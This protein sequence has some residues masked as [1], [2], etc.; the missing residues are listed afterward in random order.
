V[1]GDIGGGPLAGARISLE[2]RLLG[3]TDERGRLRLAAAGL[4][5]RG[6][7]QA[8]AD[9][10]APG[11]ASFVVP[12]AAALRLHPQSAVAGVV[13]RS[14]DGRPVA[15]VTVTAGGLRSISDGAGR[16]ALRGLGPGIYTLEAQSERWFGRSAHPLALGMGRTEHDVRLPVSPAFVVYGRLTEADAPVGGASLELAGSV[17]TTDQ[18]GRFRITGVL[19]GSHTLR[20]LGRLDAPDK[21]SRMVEIRDRDV[22]VN[23]DLEA[24]YTLE[25]VVTDEAKQPL[26]QVRVEARLLRG[27]ATMRVHCLTSTQG[28][29]AIKG[30]SAGVI[31]ELGPVGG[32]RLSVQLPGAHLAPVRFVIPGVSGVEGT[33]TAADGRPARRRL[34]D[35]VSREGPA[36]FQKF[37]ET[38]V[39]G[40][41]SFEH[42]PAGRYVL[43]IR[44]AASAS[45]DDRLVVMSPEPP[46]LEQAIETIA[47]RISRLAL[48][49]DTETGR[50]RGTVVESGGGPAADA[51]VTYRPAHASEPWQ[52][53]MPGL[54]TLVTDETGQFSFSDVPRSES[55]RIMAYRATGEV[56]S[57]DPVKPD[58]R[59]LRL[60]LTPVGQL[61]VRLGPEGGGALRQGAL[62][63]V[64]SG[65]STIAMRVCEAGGSTVTFESLPAEVPLEVSARAGEQQIRQGVTLSPAQTSEL[66]L[67]LAAR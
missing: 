5:G 28:A 23:I 18:T 42:L 7:V 1:V 21:L 33:V 64:S 4:P 13:V 47:G 8:E 34:I 27:Q 43:S 41:F 14:D 56:S 48:R 55:Y 32:P 29:C 51:I 30:L 31:D 58:G 62:V 49:L 54:E 38:D 17:A 40:A 46:E 45:A 57:S 36:P 65:G 3:H 2:G 25:A 39:A 11:W 10:Y 24:S 19:P 52:P 44:P 53:F 12:G 37:A 20:V 63:E 50:F 22:E 35:L 26:D 66:G 61:R 59:A 67:T 9:G 15:G 60:K 6:E 16:F